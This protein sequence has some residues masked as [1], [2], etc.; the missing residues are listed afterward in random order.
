[1]PDP[2]TQSNYLQIT[3][4]HASFDWRVDFQKKIISGSVVHDLRVKEVGVK[5]IMLVGLYWI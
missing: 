5:E 2:T 3:T 4:E 1:M